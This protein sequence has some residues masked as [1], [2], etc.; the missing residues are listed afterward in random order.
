MELLISSIIG[1]IA[2]VSV[3][4][5]YCLNHRARL[6]SE[7]P[8]VAIWMV[9]EQRRIF[10]FKASR[11]GNSYGWEIIGV[12]VDRA[13]RKDCLSLHPVR[14]ETLIQWGAELDFVPPISCGEVK[15]LRIHP[16]CP[17]GWLAFHFRKP[18]KRWWKK[19]DERS[20]PSVQF[21]SERVR[22]DSRILVR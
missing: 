22:A 6:R 16:D 15:S 7:L 2:I 19:W 10:N 3:W 8:D 5:T 4:A 21:L 17:R 1:G 12:K 14:E 18:S 9:N 13:T 20:L 11:S